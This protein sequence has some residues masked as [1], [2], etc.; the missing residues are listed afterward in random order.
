MK[1]V[2]NRLLFASAGAAVLALGSLTAPAE[3]ARLFGFEGTTSPIKGSFL[4]DDSVT[5]ILPGNV[6]G[7][8]PQAVLQFDV[9]TLELFNLNA[10]ALNATFIGQDVLTFGYTG[11]LVSF[12]F[13]DPNQFPSTS[14]TDILDSL[15]GTTARLVFADNP[16]LNFEVAFTLQSVPEPTSVLGL[17]ALGGVSGLLLKRKQV[18]KSNE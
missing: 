11:P 9:G 15:D 4:V 17:L 14:L 12:L 18:L 10:G 7:V 1:K 6:L 13:G 5:N 8:Y 3:A 2:L 16:R